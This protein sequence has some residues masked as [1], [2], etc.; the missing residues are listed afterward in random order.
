M[1]LYIRCQPPVRFMF[2]AYRNHLLRACYLF[3]VI[4][5]P[6]LVSTIFLCRDHVRLEAYRAFKLCHFP[7]AYYPLSLPTILSILHIHVR[8]AS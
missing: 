8:C 1:S 3:L 4:S 2:S 6:L 5:L 7:E